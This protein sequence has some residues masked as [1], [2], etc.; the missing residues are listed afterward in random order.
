MKC[1]VFI[2]FLLLISIVFV[3]AQTSRNKIEINLPDVDGK[4]IS[5]SSL[6]GKVVL[7]DFWASW[8]GP[9]RKANKGLKKIYD[10]YQSQGFEIYGISEDYNTNNWKRAIKNDKINWLQVYDEDGTIANQWQINYLPS[11]FLL[12]KNGKIVARDL[13]EDDLEKAIK[14]LL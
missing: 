13:K 2:S 8:C 12:N 4:I 14:S 11:N 1:K 6:R 10:K 7:I 3:Q 5:V 9:C